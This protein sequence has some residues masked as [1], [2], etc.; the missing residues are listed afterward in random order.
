VYP[1]IPIVAIM[2]FVF[3]GCDEL[4]HVRLM[5]KHAKSAPCV[6]CTTF[7]S[8]RLK[9]ISKR[10]QRAISCRLRYNH[11]WGMAYVPAKIL[12][13]QQMSF[14]RIND[15]ASALRFAAEASGGSVGC[16][17]VINR[18]FL[19]RHDVARRLNPNFGIRVVFKYIFLL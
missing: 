9:R 3:K 4:V 11:Q 16:P 1:L 8:L 13:R 12:F 18:Q 7:A 15:P 5:P 2:C 10:M 19:V 17:S 14:S 6:L